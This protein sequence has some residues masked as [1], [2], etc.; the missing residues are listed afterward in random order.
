MKKILSLLLLCAVML[1]SSA[2]AQGSKKN[3]RNS[4]KNKTT[5]VI[6][7][8]QKVRESDYMTFTKYTAFGTKDT[9]IYYSTFNYTDLPALCAV[10]NPNW[11]EDIRPVMNYLQKVSRATMTMT[12]LFAVNP[13][14]TDNAQRQE[15]VNQAREE[16]QACLESFNDWKAKKG[17]RNKTQYKIA[18]VDY[19]YFKGS[20][21]YNEMRGDDIIHVGVL[22]YLGSK[23][24]SIFTADTVSRSFQDI[25]FFPN[26]ATLL[27]SWIPMI[28]ELA[29]YLGEND[30]RGVLLTGYCDNQGTEEYCIGVSRQRAMEV[31]KALMLR[32]VEDNRIEISAKGDADPIGDNSTYEGRILNNRVSIKVQ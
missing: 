22:I 21:Y 13:D 14:I 6:E 19:R 17:M 32:G 27:E 10:T 4:K 29:L 31:K 9:K 2:A 26:D 30:R 23:K 1:C 24:N 20:N 16:A 8:R 11:G 5:E 28:D 12:A 7:G 25:K 18:E 15:L 3:N